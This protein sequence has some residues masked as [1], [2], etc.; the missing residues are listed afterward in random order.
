MLYNNV[1]DWREYYHRTLRERPEGDKKH[2]LARRKRYS[3]RMR[4]KSPAELMSLSYSHQA[5][6][7]ERLLVLNELSRRIRYEGLN[8][9]N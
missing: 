9:G 1:D 3:D 4:T 8:T 2:F 5:P 6:I 7:D